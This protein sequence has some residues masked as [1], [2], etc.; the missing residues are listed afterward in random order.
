MSGQIFDIYRK[1][2][3]DDTI[4]KIEL[5]TYLPYIKSFNNNDVIDIQIKQGDAWLQMYNAALVIEGKLTKTEGDGTVNFVN[6]PAAFFFEQISYSIDG[7]EVDSV[8]DP[9]IVSSIKGYLCYS[10]NDTKHLA[11]AGWNFPGNP[12]INAA[13]S[14]FVMRVPLN[15]L[16]NVFNDYQMAQF[17]KQSI[18]LVRARTDNDAILTT[19]TA[20]GEVTIEN[21]SL[22]VPVVYPNDMLKLQLL[23]SIKTDRPII[24]PFRK[25]EFHEL[26]QLTENAQKEVWSVKTA[27]ALESPRYV[28]LAFQTDK[29]GNA[30]SNASQFDHI[31]IS[32]IRVMLNN[33]YYPAERMRLDFEHN[34]FVEAHYN[35]TEFY[36][37]FKGSHDKDPLLDYT[38]FKDRALFVV[39]CSRR[40]DPIKMSTV[41]VKVDIEARKGFP[42][43]TKA[44]CIIIHDVIMEHLPLSEI[45]RN[46]L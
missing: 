36:S 25:W 2:Q 10:A 18:R 19:N 46:F 22:R 29:R 34:H 20:R 11:I 42:A 15:H 9:G 14:T 26:P 5:R 3:F 43:K 40:N 1:A 45:V 4:Q 33:E 37:S 32:D 6:N 28:I 24:I 21:I 17:G 7:Q 8:R 13:D 35:Y 12:I 41:D 27:T 30:T 31:D 39:D 38:T 44:Y 23:E 16:F